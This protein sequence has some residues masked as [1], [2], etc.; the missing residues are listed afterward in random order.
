MSVGLALGAC[1]A[2]VH[3]ANDGVGHPP[4]DGGQD[5]GRDGSAGGTE[6][7]DRP[8]ERI[9]VDG[10]LAIVLT[11]DGSGYGPTPPPDSSCHG[12]AEYRYVLGSRELSWTECATG[13]GSQPWDEVSGARTIDD[14]DHDRVLAALRAVVVTSEERCGVDKPVRTIA[15]KTADAEQLYTDSFYSCRGDAAP[16]VDGIDGVF[17]ELSSLASDTPLGCHAEPVC[18]LGRTQ[19]ESR[20]ECDAGGWDCEQMTLCGSTIWCGMTDADCDYAQQVYEDFLAANDACTIDA[21]CA[22]IGDCCPN[23]DF[24][25][26]RADA[27]T[28]GRELQNARCGGACDG[29]TYEAYCNA[30]TCAL[31]QQ[32]PST[33]YGCPPLWDGDAGAE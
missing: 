18:P 25:A 11:D 22:V 9:L 14:A 24:A 12:E 17:I 5:A 19:F 1:D 8:G 3:D 15:V 13:N 20:S 4:P 33:E 23:A 32:P 26:I 2:E 31:R 21:D 29:P 10:T 28:E 30:G 16:Y 27:A 7:A 6:L